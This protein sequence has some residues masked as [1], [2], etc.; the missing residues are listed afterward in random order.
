[1]V[2]WGRFNDAGTKFLIV[3]EVRQKGGSNDSTVTKHDP[4]VEDGDVHLHSARAHKLATEEFFREA[5]PQRPYNISV[6]AAANGQWYVYAIPAQTYTAVLPYGGDVRDVVSADGTKI[7]EKRQMHK[8]VLEETIGDPTEFGFHTHVLS[9][10]PED[11]DV[12]YAL[13]RKAARGEWIGTK[14]YFY[15]IRLPGS[16]KYLRTTAETVKL[17]HDSKVQTLD[18]SYKAMVLSSA[19]CLLEEA[20]SGN[21]LEAFTSFSGARCADSTLWLKFAIALHN[22][23]EQ[24]IILY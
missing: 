3:Y 5:K 21:P 23:G 17:L 15:E 19:Q 9:D 11:S 2:A 22:V 13:T 1:V 10:V 7:L 16:L 12:F 14:D 24:K 18:E 8:T 20:S 6:L 4:P